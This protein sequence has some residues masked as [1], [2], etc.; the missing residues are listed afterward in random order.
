[1]HQTSVEVIIRA[2]RM[3]MHEHDVSSETALGLLVWA[4]TDRG[5]T[6][7]EVADNICGTASHEHPNLGEVGSYATA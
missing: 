3:L 4:A 7:L 5:V 1:M 6:V 2:Q